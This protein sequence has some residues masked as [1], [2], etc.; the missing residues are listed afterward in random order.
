[1]PEEIN[2]STELNFDGLVGPTHHYAGLAFGNVASE[3]NKNKP[4][5]PKQAA[6]Q[7]LQKIQWMQQQGVLQGML[8]PQ[9]RPNFRL[10]HQ[11]G[12]QGREQAVLD[13][14]YK[15]APQLLSACCSA[16]SMWTA[17][18]A[19]VA[20]SSDTKHH[21]LCIT[22][23]NLICN[24]HRSLE[25][26]ANYALLSY[27]FSNKDHFQVNESLPA[28]STYSDEGAANHMRI[29]YG[30]QQKALH[31]FVY[32]RDSE[33]KSPTKNFPARQTKQASEAV[34]RLNQLNNRN[35]LLLQQN[36][37]A[38]DMGV[39]H[40]DVIALSHDGLLLCHEL[41][42]MNQKDVMDEIKER[43]EGCI[44]I[45]EIQE[46]EL[47]LSNAISS[48]LFNSQIV[49]CSDGVLKM[50]LPLE[51]REQ[52]KVHSLIENTIKPKANI[53]ETQYMDLRQSMRNGGGPA[54]LRLRINMTLEER[55]NLNGKLIVN[56]DQMKELRRIIEQ[57][58][59]E[60]LTLKQL[61]SWQECQTLLD[62]VCAIY[63]ILEIPQS[64]FDGI[65]KIPAR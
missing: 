49:T 54:C 48:Y 6:L 30:K 18:A 34:I 53:A 35:A 20:P 51:C 19:T 7:G 23:A 61:S 9:L 8:P 21:K 39:F 4:A 29:A 45:I 60:Q 64:L 38:I 3:K 16:S 59:P 14:V 47:S 40:N 37:Q 50:L 24:L 27:V 12:F 43:S 36:P 11:L 33:R 25:S 44:K 28:L 5:N 41:A 58:Y 2:T 22:P 46:A 13:R 62:A 10:L 26:T 32:G 65:S 55:E 1:M 17:N 42:F 31:I 56:E 57:Y 63:E 52:E 15:Q